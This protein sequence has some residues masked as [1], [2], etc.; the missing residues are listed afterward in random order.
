MQNELCKNTELKRRI[1][2][3]ICQNKKN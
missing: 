3:K 1:V 2:T